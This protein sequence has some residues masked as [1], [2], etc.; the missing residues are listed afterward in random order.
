M[1]YTFSVMT[2][3]QA[4]LIAF[5]WHY[6]GEYAFYDMEADEEDLEEF[7]DPKV[8]GDS[9]FA[10][11]YNGELVGFFS[12]S[13]DLEIALGMRPD[14][15]GQ[16]KGYEFLKVCLDFAEAR[17]QPEK[18]TLSVATFNKR[19]IKVYKRLGFRE[20]ETFSQKTNGG[21]Y[22]FVKMAT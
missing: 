22:E 17:F 2:Q 11:T 5:E 15:T 21:I 1:T 3:K 16:G 19:A 14:L 10:V 6:E 18:I 13:P 20:L 9:M 7:L 12:M 4:E 8:R